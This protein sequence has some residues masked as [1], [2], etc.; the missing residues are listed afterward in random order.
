MDIFKIQNPAETFI[1]WIFYY[2]FVDTAY[3]RIYS[4]SLDDM[5]LILTLFEN[6]PSQQVVSIN[7]A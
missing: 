2:S 4:E 7:L 1:L 6:E 5:T 3:S